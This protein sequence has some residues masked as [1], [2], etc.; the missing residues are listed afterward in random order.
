M[1]HAPPLLAGWESYYVIIGS[2][3]AALTGLQFV[4]MTL[5]ADSP[6]RRSWETISAFGTPTIVHFCY[7]LLISAVLSAPWP[8][9]EI[10]R[11][12]MAAIGVAGGI[13]TLLVMR[14]ATRQ[15]LYQPVVEDWVFHVILPLLA[16]GLLCVASA[17][18][19]SHAVGALFVIAASSLLLIFIGI[20]NAWDTVSYLI[21]RA[22]SRAEG[23][24]ETSSPG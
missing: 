18:F 23:G 11:Y 1:E 16:Y 21:M 14:R 6:T 9:A 19:A 17:I 3:A 22:A 13:Y 10:T 20:H 7:S 12:P 24:D 2:S 8:S 4:V 5:I 15:T